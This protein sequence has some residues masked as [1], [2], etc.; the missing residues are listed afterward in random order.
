MIIAAS[1]ARRKAVGGVCAPAGRGGSGG[2]DKPFYGLPRGFGDRG[3]DDAESGFRRR[4]RPPGERPAGRSGAGGAGGRARGGVRRRCLEQGGGIVRLCR[5]GTIYAES[6]FSAGLRGAGLQVGGGRG[7][8]GED[9]FDYPYHACAHA[10]ARVG[11]Y[12]FASS[13]VLPQTPLTW[14]ASRLMR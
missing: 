3:A 14:C 13:P 5:P 4:P 8:T 1:C 11:D 10:R 6:R 2:Y 7:R 12:R 9:D